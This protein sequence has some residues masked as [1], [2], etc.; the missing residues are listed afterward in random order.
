LWGTRKE[1]EDRAGRGTLERESSILGKSNLTRTKNAAPREGGG[2]RK[3][4]SKGTRRRR[5][6]I[7]LPR[8]TRPS[9]KFMKTYP[10]TEAKKE[11]REV[12][13]NGGKEIRGKRSNY[14]LPGFCG[15]REGSLRRRKVTFGRPRGEESKAIGGESNSE[16]T[17]LHGRRKPVRERRGRKGES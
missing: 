14:E 3:L 7:S 11:E 13:R 15:N 9:M 6:S 1:G 4:L 12:F 5:D 16:K 2:K 17:F 8:A 10:P